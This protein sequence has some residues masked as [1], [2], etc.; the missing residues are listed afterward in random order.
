MQDM[1]VASASPAPSSDVTV[2]PTGGLILS[3]AP[4]LSGL[5]MVSYLEIALQLALLLFAP[6][7]YHAISISRLL[8][9]T[10]TLAS[11]D[12]PPRTLLASG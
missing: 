1:G 4:G 5:I 3:V 11:P 8:K 12:P 2:T 10:I 9:R 7:A 6:L